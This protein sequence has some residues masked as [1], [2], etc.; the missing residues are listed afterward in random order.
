MSNHVQSAWELQILII[1]QPWKHQGNILN[2]FNIIFSEKIRWHFMWII[3]YA[4][5][6]HEM[7]SHTFSEK[8]KKK[9]TTQKKTKNNIVY[10]SC[11]YH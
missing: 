3:C 2:F 11:D 1:P 6:S 5:D 4:D 8:Y 7:S 10:C 9:T